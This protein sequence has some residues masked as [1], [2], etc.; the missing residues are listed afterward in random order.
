ML[1]TKRQSKLLDD[2]WWRWLA[3]ESLAPRFGRND[4][5]RAF[6]GCGIASVRGMRYV[7]PVAFRH[8]PDRIALRKIQPK[9]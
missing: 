2:V 3:A 9:L 6:N 4:F 8:V 1:Q 5:R 7:N